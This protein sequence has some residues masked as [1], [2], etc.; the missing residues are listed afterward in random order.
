MAGAIFPGASIR[1][2]PPTDQASWREG[3][4]ALSSQ[5]QSSGYKR[6]SSGKR[7]RRPAPATTPL[8]EPQDGTG[9]TDAAIATHAVEPV[10]TKPAARNGV[11]TAKNRSAA[12]TVATQ[13]P[14]KWQQLVNL[15]RF[16]GLRKFIRETWAEIKK[17][18]WPDRETTRNLTLVVIAVSVVLG[19]LLGGIDYVLY[20]LFEALP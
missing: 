5:Q 7:T 14:S 11:T 20:Q 19:I 13:E 3:F 18:I 12:K 9:V 10:T 15:D 17:V 2:A 1:A 4:K 16:E 8:A 6:R